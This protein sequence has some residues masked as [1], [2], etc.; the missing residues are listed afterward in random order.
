[1]DNGQT[2]L[3][4]EK[5]VIGALLLDPTKTREA[6]QHVAPGDFHSNALAGLY[7]L[8]TTKHATGESIDPLTVW[9]DVQADASLM[10]NVKSAA[11]LHDLMH[12]TPTAEN[13]GYYARQVADAGQSRRLMQYATRLNQIA[14]DM[15]MPAT[16]KLNIARQEIEHIA[17][18]YST[19]IDFAHG[20]DFWQSNIL[21]PKSLRDKYDTLRLQAKRE[22]N[23]SQPQTQKP[24]IQQWVHY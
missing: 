14:G 3:E 20:H 5:A 15:S 17:S 12:N 13:V 6:I 10:R 16:E 8:I 19:A 4:A 1:M 22:Q 18:D 23:Q 7:G 11:M 2:S 24:L 21:S 9:A